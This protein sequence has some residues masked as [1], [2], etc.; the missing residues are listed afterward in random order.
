[1]WDACALTLQNKIGRSAL[2]LATA[3]IIAAAAFPYGAPWLLVIERDEVKRI[4]TMKQ[5]ILGATLVGA[6]ISSTAAMAAERTATLAVENM[7]CPS[8]PYIVK[9]SMESV[10]GVSN[11]NVS[12]E[13][14]TATVTFDRSEERRVG[15]ECVST[16]RSRWSP[17]H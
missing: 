17:D 11:V 4:R 6:L 1:M 16:G 5:L 9:T 14:K 15:K 10:S 8:C 7:T 13:E 12:Y 2:W 3:M